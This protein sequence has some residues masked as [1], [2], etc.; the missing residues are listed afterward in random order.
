MAREYV[1]VRHH[2]CTSD[3]DHSNLNEPLV[4]IIAGPVKHPSELTAQKQQVEKSGALCHIIYGAHVLFKHVRLIAVSLIGISLTY[5]PL[6]LNAWVMS[7][8]GRF[9]LPDGDNINPNISRR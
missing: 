7:L 1:L 6:D 3:C 8:P 9:P 2:A 5:K 4:E